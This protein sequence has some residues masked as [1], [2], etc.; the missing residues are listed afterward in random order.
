MFEALRMA[1]ALTGLMQNREK[2][3]KAMEQV[4]AELGQKRIDGTDPGRMVRVVVSGHLQVTEVKIT[5]GVVGQA[6]AGPA[7]ERAVA[8]ATNDALA[9]AFVVIGERVSKEAEALGLNGLP[10]MGELTSLLRK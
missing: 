5:P 10:G 6:S 8:E 9:K 3:T 1:G 4:K 2:L 7:L